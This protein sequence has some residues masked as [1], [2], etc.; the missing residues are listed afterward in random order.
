MDEATAS[1]DYDTDVRIQET[2]RDLKVTTVTIAHRLQTITDHDKVLVLDEG[3]VSEFGH[4]Y[5]C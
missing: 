3:K 2:I 4:P 1:I 5:G